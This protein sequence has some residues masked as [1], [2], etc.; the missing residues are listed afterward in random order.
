MGS[1]EILR[2]AAKTVRESWCQRA[3]ARDANGVSV[4]VFATGSSETGRAGINPR[5]VAFSAY[6]AII[7]AQYELRESLTTADWDLI[8][9]RAARQ[10]GKPLGGSNYVHPLVQLNEDEDRSAG[11][12]ATFLEACADEL[13]RGETA[14]APIVVPVRPEAEASLVIAAPP[15]PVERPAPIRP[16]ETAPVLVP[17]TGA[18]GSGLAAAVKPAVNPE[19]IPPVSF[20]PRSILPNPFES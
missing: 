10:H 2:L 18:A 20:A 13:G 15:E 8:H 5:A 4:P 19:V 3:E 1:Q 9:A 6:A 7:K 17:L 16:P 11:F 12:M 14:P